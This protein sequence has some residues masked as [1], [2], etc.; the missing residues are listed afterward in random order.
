MVGGQWKHAD[1]RYPDKSK[2]LT[3]GKKYDRWTGGDGEFVTTHWTIAV[4][5][6]Y[7]LQVA[8]VTRTRAGVEIEVL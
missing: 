7:K 1:F 5:D 3:V 8:K 4:P 6:D 2:K